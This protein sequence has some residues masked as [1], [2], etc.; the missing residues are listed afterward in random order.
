MALLLI[1][2]V[3]FFSGA[4]QG[5]RTAAGAP[6]GAY[7]KNKAHASEKWGDGFGSTVAAVGVTTMRSGGIVGRAFGRGAKSGWRSGWKRAS[8]RFGRP[9]IEQEPVIAPPKPA[10]PPKPVA[11][12]P[13]PEIVVEPAPVIEP[14]VAPD[15]VVVPKS[16]SVPTPV[17]PTT[18]PP[19]P[20]RTTPVALI[21]DNAD[22]NTYSGLLAFLEALKDHAAAELD[23]A[24]AELT[25]T[26]DSASVIDTRYAGFSSVNLDSESLGALGGLLDPIG[27]RRDAA[28]ARVG[29]AEALFSQASSAQDFAVAKHSVMNEAY[30]VTPDH[31]DQEFYDMANQ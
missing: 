18:A 11:A 23:D 15:P 12:P 14:V 16:A 3:S 30:A 19:V 5:M 29:A 13:A 22:D 27:A 2:L 6:G 4:H 17:T 20:E 25:R 24:Q 8:D 9:V 28:Q 10:A 21:N 7:K 26:E 1:I 31:A